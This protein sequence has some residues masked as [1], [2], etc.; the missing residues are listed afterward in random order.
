VAA[1]TLSAEFEICAT[2][3]GMTEAEL[4]QC[5]RIAHEAGFDS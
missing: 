3:M 2:E 4:D 1:T 5:N